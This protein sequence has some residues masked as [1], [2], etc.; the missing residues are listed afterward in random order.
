MAAAKN[1]NP[2]PSGGATANGH[3]DTA[4][5]S[6]S[7]STAT[8]TATP[9]QQAPVALDIIVVGA[10]ISGLATAISCV[11]S[12][13][14]VTV[15]ESAKELLEIGAGLQVTPNATRILQRWG[16]LDS[17]AAADDGPA[18]T[19]T[20]DLAVQTPNL[21]HTAAEPTSLTVHRYTGTVLAHEESFD[22]KMR[23]RYAA[24]FLD[25]HRVDLQRA[26]LARARSLG[27]RFRLGEQVEAVVDDFSSSSFSSSSNT[28][29]DSH[30]HHH[31]HK[32]AVTTKAGETV[33]ADMVV[34][35]DG[36]WSKCQTSYLGAEHARPPLPTGDLAYRVVFSMDQLQHSDDEDL[37]QWVQNP[38]VH[39]WIGP[40]AHA[41]GYSMR[42]GDM[43]NI[44][45]L[46]P[47]N[48]PDG[49]SRQPGSL[50]EMKAL[51]TAWDPILKRFLDRVETVEKWRLMHREELQ[52]WVNDKGNFVF[53]GDS[54][55][56]MLPY[57]AQGANSAVE[58]GA[59]L[60]QLLGH[61][62][63]TADIPKALNMYETLRKA[64]G[65]AIVRETFKQRRDFHL[66]DGPEQE[67]RDVVFKSQLGK[68]IEGA[69][70]SR[71]TCPEVQPWLY[72]YDAYREVEDAVAQDPF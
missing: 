60:G 54:C 9:Q 1:D 35:A 45:L 36:V 59:V 39:F 29:G 27:V 38:T 69:F 11:L 5:T 6:S 40:G 43:Y 23:A 68:E 56:P 64:R 32:A 25:L 22:K 14:K 71:W 61:I 17:S 63:T 58:D 21:W 34:A 13:H 52:S 70:P 2:A 8:T 50:E 67:K 47:D 65:E 26:L 31:H 37:R 20:D 41:V 24:P 53:V 18:T 66:P 55:H 46:V 48:L 30:H 49:V 51:F 33:S 16:L 12:G 19:T 15:F 10:G 72:G 3:R 44:V 62:K 7:S 28:D 42:R 4:T 57:L